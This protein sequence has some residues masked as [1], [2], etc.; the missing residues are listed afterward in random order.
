MEDYVGAIRKKI[1]H[2]R[3]IFNCA[4]CIIFDE[5]GRLL[6]QKRTDCEMW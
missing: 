6:L 5:R 4:G 1:G 2:D 3:L